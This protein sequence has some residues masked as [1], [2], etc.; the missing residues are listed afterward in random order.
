MDKDAL[1]NLWNLEDLPACP[2]GMALAKTF[3]IACGQGVNRLG[4]EEPDDR[5]LDIT[6]CY[7]D[8][9]E[10]AGDCDDCKEI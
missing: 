9:V 5:L 10:H 6:A 1:L 4:T 8:L 3:L 7:M 2:A